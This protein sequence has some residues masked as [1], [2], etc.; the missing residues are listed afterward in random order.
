MQ[1]RHASPRSI[2]IGFPEA[3]VAPRCVHPAGSVPLVVAL[4]D[5]RRVAVVEVAPAFQSP[6]L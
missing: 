1:V 3:S 6:S 5:A 2:V 4:S